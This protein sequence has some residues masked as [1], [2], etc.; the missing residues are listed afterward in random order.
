M[1]KDLNQSGIY[2][3]TNRKSGK[4]Y[5]GSAVNL[6][7]RFTEHRWSLRQNKHYNKHLQ[8]SWNLYGEDSFVF[9]I[10]ELCPPASLLKKE[11]SWI[12]RLEACENGYN[13]CQTASNRLGAKDS[14]VTKDRK[15][16]AAIGRKH[17]DQTKKK[18]SLKKKGQ[19]SPF[20][21]RKHSLDSKEKMSKSSPLRQKTQCKN[22]HEFNSQNTY[23]FIGTNGNQ[24]R[25]CRECHKENQK[26]Y[27]ERKQQCQ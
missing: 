4:V 11:T 27:L 5:V 19:I 10:I 23:S 6:R 24:H 18:M 20:T 25:Y 3:I 1:I 12:A 22:G 16:R 8:N 2:K 26:R 17:T 13:I 7:K 9:E 14:S 15:S 21:G